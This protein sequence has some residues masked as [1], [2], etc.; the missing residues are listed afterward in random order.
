MRSA[1]RITETQRA[2]HAIRVRIPKLAEA[3]V[4][5]QYRRRPELEARY[6][7]AGRAK[8]VQ[9]TA[10]HLRFLA[11]S[12]EFGQTKVFEDYVAWAV[13]VMKAHRVAAEDAVENLRLIAGVLR[14]RLPPAA[15]AAATEHVDA[16]L[17]R[18]GTQWCAV[19]PPS[20]P[21]ASTGGS[22]PSRS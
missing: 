8:C 18:V 6:G 7:P 15:A 4:D 16:A 11:G 1:I 14:D 22:A 19:I 9:D 3:V 17:L 13:R 2:G 20:P 10:Y 12:V 5:E 21:A